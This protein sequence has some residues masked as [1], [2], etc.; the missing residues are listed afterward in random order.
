MDMVYY[1]S[2]KDLKF[3]IKFSVSITIRN[4]CI[5]LDKKTPKVYTMNWISIGRQVS[6]IRILTLQASYTII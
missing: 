2:H 4:P 3:C 1:N 5:Y 6:I